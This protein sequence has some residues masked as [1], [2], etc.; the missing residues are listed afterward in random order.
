MQ[1]KS[2]NKFNT[3]FTQYLLKIQYLKSVY[4]LSAI[5]KCQMESLTAWYVWSSLLLLFITS[6]CET[7]NKNVD[8]SCL[9]PGHAQVSAAQCRGSRRRPV[10]WPITCLP[11]AFCAAP[12]S[13]PPSPPS[14]VNWCSAASTQIFRGPFWYE[15]MMETITVIYT[16]VSSHWW[17]FSLWLRVALRSWLLKGRLRFIS[18]SSSISDKLIA[19]S[20]IS[21]RWTRPELIFKPLLDSIHV[22]LISHS[23]ERHYRATLPDFSQ[24][25]DL[26]F[27]S[28]WMWLLRLEFEQRFSFVSVDII[29][30]ESW[31]LLI[32]WALTF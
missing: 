16:H 2:F 26:V 6:F 31:A 32:L 13:S 10:R 3:Y 18:S 27:S 17:H 7:V 22:I 24:T 1:I 28:L 29:R 8:K 20:S 30:P 9:S 14:W 5:F 11:H 12:S 23:F 25:L 21:L 4:Y 19:R 15:N